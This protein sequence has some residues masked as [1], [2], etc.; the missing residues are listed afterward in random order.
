M[1]LTKNQKVLKVLV[2][3]MLR[4][5]YKTGTEPNPPEDV[6]TGMNILRM[7]LPSRIVVMSTST[8]IADDFVQALKRP[9]NGV[10]YLC[11][12]DDIERLH[13][14]NNIHI[15]QLYSGALN[16]VQ[17]EIRRR[18]LAG[19][20]AYVREYTIWHVGEWRA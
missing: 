2:E 1:E 14:F 3:E 10:I 6:E 18:I 12:T 13:G 16:S 9:R 19:L 15:V 20:Q 4:R 8:R 11:G 7:L 17:G 5:S